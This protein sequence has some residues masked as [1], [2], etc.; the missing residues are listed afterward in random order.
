MQIHIFIF[1]NGSIWSRTHCRCHI[2][3]GPGPNIAAIFGPTGQNMDA[4][5]GPR[6]DIIWH[7]G[8]EYGS[9][10]RINRLMGLA[11]GKSCGPLQPC[12]PCLV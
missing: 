12:M 4:V 3:F 6:A 9:Q 1:L 11:R 2:R 8:T 5:F 7:G 10:C